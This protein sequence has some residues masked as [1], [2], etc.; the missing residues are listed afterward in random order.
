MSNFMP[1]Q[2]DRVYFRA[3]QQQAASAEKKK[4]S[5]LVLVI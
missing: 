3:Q 5:V 2:A 4:V 1:I